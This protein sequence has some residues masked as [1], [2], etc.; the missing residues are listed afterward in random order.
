M[1]KQVLLDMDGTLTTVTS[2]WQYVHEQLG[3]WEAKGLPYL[4]AWLDGDMSYEQFCIKDAAAWSKEGLHLQDVYKILATIPVP[5][6]TY[7]FLGRCKE[8]GIRPSIISTGFEFNAEMILGN[9]GFT[10]DQADIAAN[11]LVEKDGVIVPE[12]NVVVGE[13]LAGKR[14][15]ARKLMELHG[16]AAGEAGAIGDSSADIPLFESVEF[17]LKVAGPQELANAPWLE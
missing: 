11:G 14:E 17:S 13:G 1:I 2:P 12:L 16:V 5:D 6:A 7:R 10:G 3:I 9:A 8:L 4:T 15:W